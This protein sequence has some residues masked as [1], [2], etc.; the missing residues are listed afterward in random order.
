MRARI[1]YV[2]I[3]WLGRASFGTRSGSLVCG[4]DAG[5]YVVNINGRAQRFMADEVRIQLIKG[6]PFV[7]GSEVRP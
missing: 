7:V 3:D 2:W 5:E 6:G 1:K 4:P